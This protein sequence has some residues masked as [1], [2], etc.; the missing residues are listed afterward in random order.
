MKKGLGPF[1]QLLFGT[2]LVAAGI[3]GGMYLCYP[4]LRVSLGE[5]FTL[6]EMYFPDT[7]P[8]NVPPRTVLTTSNLDVLWVQEM[9]IDNP[10]KI[11]VDLFVPNEEF[12][13][14]WSPQSEMLTALDFV[15]GR[16][17]W[18]TAVP[19]VSDIALYDGHFHI[20]SD[21]WIDKLN[22]AP[23]SMYRSLNTCSFA[24][25]AT[26]VKIDATTGSR[27]WGYSYWGS[28]GRG[29]SISQNNI[30][31]SGSG[32]HGASRSAVRVDATNGT[33]LERDCYQWPEEKELP[34]E[35]AD[36]RWIP[37]LYVVVLE[38]HKGSNSGSQGIL[39]FFVAEENRLDILDGQTKEIIGTIN[40]DGADLNPWDID[41]AVQ[42]NI[43]V[44]YFGDSHQLFGF[45]LPDPN[46]D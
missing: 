24:G 9:N 36:E 18:E 22:P 5:N 6:K 30:Y 45:R 46:K 7:P 10:H 35:P 38:E 39:L 25:Q 20:S 15:T 27:T 28:S 16:V 13:V 3:F 43:A 4:P 17:M 31:L 42:G 12:L 29:F 37:P 40:F 1:L 23:V 19:H 26:L 11:E 21:D 41:V 8:E 32:D 44:I 2:L 34:Q 33:I 14:F